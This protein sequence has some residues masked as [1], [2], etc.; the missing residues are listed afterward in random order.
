MPDLVLAATHL[1]GSSDSGDLLIVGPSL[2][3]S[4]T[5]LWSECA[6]VLGDTF[7][8]VGWDLPGHGLTRPASGFSVA[9]LAEAVVSLTKGW[10]TEG[11]RCLY[12]GV[13]L[14]G[15]VGLELALRGG[16][17]EGVAVV[18][19]AAKV[20]DPAAWY[21]RAALVRRAGASVMVEP[22]SQRWFAPGFA[23]R[24]PDVVG[25][26]LS[27]LAGTDRESYGAACDAL[28][29]YDLR[30]RL[31]DAAVPLLLMPGSEDQV[32]SVAQAAETADNVPGS[33]V[34]ILDGCGHL[35]P[36]EAPADVAG[37]LL[38]FFQTDVLRANH[39]VH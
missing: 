33:K 1:A 9:D 34:H 18:A 37:V 36:A 28:A 4:V 29:A 15:A 6:K 10:R 12:A 7:Q 11:R 21:D 39:H 27:S 35:P 13:S 30:H 14:G 25:R 31:S 17:F 23:A 24:Q 5:L 3:T 38:D 2:G 22:S 20:G 8:V 19:S 26:L 32:V 16:P